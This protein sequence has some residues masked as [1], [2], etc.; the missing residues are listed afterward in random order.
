MDSLEA[1]LP[2]YLRRP[3]DHRPFKVPL[4][5]GGLVVM[6]ALPVLCLVV[7]LAAALSEVS[8][9]TNATLFAI[10]AVATAPVA[11]YILKNESTRGEE[12]FL[13]TENSVDM[14]EISTYY[15]PTLYHA[16]VNCSESSYVANARKTA[17]FQKTC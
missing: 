13:M 1:D 14:T 7:A 12:I 3:E 15:L 5:V 17:D 9:Y 6:T 16:L 10:A 11:W 8:S 4:N 2:R